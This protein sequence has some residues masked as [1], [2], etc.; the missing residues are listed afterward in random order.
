MRQKGASVEIF[1]ILQSE[2]CQELTV[3]L[4]LIDVQNETKTG[5]GIALTDS[6]NNK[7][8]VGGVEFHNEQEMEEL[9]G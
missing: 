6:Q 5:T 8:P 3:S 4:Q 1:C 9:P 2:N 7:N